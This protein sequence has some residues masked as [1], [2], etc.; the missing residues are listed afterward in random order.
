MGTL[1][2]KSWKWTFYKD[3]TV[4]GDCI[5]STQKNDEEDYSSGS[6]EDYVPSGC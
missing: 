3:V 4:T 2:I 6:D 1:Q 5:Y